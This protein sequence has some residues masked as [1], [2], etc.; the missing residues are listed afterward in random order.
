MLY[1]FVVEFDGWFYCVF[2]YFLEICWVFDVSEDNWDVF[3][4]SRDFWVEM[5][6]GGV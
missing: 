3:G 4:R 2:M 5:V 6:E 1:D